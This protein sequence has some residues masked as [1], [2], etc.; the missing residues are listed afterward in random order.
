MFNTNPAVLMSSPFHSKK[1]KKKKRK[2][3]TDLDNHGS[4]IKPKRD[5]IPLPAISDAPR[6]LQSII[7]SILQPIG[8]GMP[9]L[10]RTVLGTRDEDGEGRVKDGE[11]DVGGVAFEGLDAWFRVVVPDF[12]EAFV[13]IR[14][15]FEE[16][17]G[18]KRGGGSANP[19][20]NSTRRR[21]SQK[22]T[23]RSS[24]VVTM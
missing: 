21:A 24:P 4:L 17:E 18:S 2:R 12:D 11:R 15:L 10:D 5:I 16:R 23:H 9:N 6:P 8:R 22:N 19:S 3:G 14:V 1:K 7:Q 13:Q 20:S